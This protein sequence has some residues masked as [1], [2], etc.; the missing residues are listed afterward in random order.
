MRTLLVILAISSALFMVNL[1]GSI[2][3]VALPTLA[4]EYRTGVHQVADVIMYYLVALC[5]CLP[6]FG[7]LGDLAGRKAVFLAG[8]VVF[9]AGSVFCG[10]APGFEALRLGRLVQGVG[11][12]MLLATSMALVKENL[13][14]DR[15][16]RA[17]GLL[18][19]FAGVG[20][21]LGAP[22]GGLISGHLSWRWIF[23]VNVLPGA[24]GFWISS[25]CLAGKG[26][27]RGRWR[28]FD[29]AGA[30]LSA[31]ALVS[32][33][34]GLESLKDGSGTGM[35]LAVVSALSLAAFLLR[36]ARFP[37]PLVDLRLFRD[38]RLSL[39]FA[40]NLFVVTILG[41]LVFLLP[42]FFERA[43]GCRTDQSGLLIGV[44][45]LSTFL[46]SPVAGWL[47]DRFGS[48]RVCVAGAL[49]LVPSAAAF[50]WFRPESGLAVVIPVMLLYGV[51]YAS[52]VTGNT[53]LV[54]QRAP[55]GQEGVVSSLFA[56]ITFLASVFGVILFEWLFAVGAPGGADPASCPAAAVA[57]GFRFAA[58]S[59]VAL[60]VLALA[61]SLAELYLSGR[62]L[63]KQE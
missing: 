62:R 58:G 59:G 50:L 11:G 51:G 9:T 8:F 34:G 52:F 37:R 10:L 48:S 55:A 29:W 43:M 22:L 24:A 44:F 35:A 3:N 18:A 21:S 25:R 33:V 27:Q 46:V 2:V 63:V 19:V 60:A 38:A 14:P 40:A 16:G 13:P 15:T 45:P 17:F 56:E 61:A 28:D 31:A 42:F 32:L 12:A 4:R 23:W 6:V 26:G 57:E 49:L 1:D 36:E 39:G 53:N 20:Y 5:A 41:G 54:I 30:A 7:R 47:A